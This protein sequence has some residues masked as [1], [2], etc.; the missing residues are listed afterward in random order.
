MFVKIGCSQFQDQCVCVCVRIVPFHAAIFQNQKIIVCGKF[1]LFP[2]IRFRVFQRCVGVG[3]VAVT[4]ITADMVVLGCGPG[5]D[6]GCCGLLLLSSSLWLLLLFL[7]LL[8][9]WLL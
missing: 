1:V 2:A 5:Y 9:L 8:L 4:A 6:R 7:L 3:A